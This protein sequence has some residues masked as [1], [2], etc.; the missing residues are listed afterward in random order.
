MLPVRLLALLC[1]IAALAPIAASASTGTWATHQSTG[2]GFTVAAPSTWIDMTR[3]SPQVLAKTKTIPALQQYVDL[4]RTTKAIKLLLADASVTS[5]ANHYATNLNVIQA[6][7]VGDLKY[8][9]DAS[10]ASL[11]STGVV[12]GA[13]HSAYVTLP[14][15]KAAHLTYVARFQA[16]TPEVALQQFILMHGGTVTILTYTTLPKLR[17]TYAAPIS[18]SVHSFR[19]R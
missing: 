6:P 8:M 12:Q 2:G 4:L 3:L 14:A 19:F 15:G 1:V 13:I 7:T 16:G 18:R 9:R 11:Q 5:I 17:H 10:I